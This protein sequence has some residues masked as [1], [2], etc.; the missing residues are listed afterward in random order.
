ML[1]DDTVSL[2][3]SYEELLRLRERVALLSRRKQK[4][5]KPNA[6][7]RHRPRGKGSPKRP[8]R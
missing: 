2:E 7:K 3:A 5:T 8:R 6:R 1:F 4:K